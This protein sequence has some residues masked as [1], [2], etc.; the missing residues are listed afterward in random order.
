MDMVYVHV[1]AGLLSA[2]M[3]LIATIITLFLV[4]KSFS[5]KPGSSIRGV[6]LILFY[7]LFSAVFL[8]GGSVWL[9]DISRPFNM[10]AGIS[11]LIEVLLI[12][13][14]YGFLI[15]VLYLRLFLLEMKH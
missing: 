2:S 14:G 13:V 10:F 6:S 9:S 12:H 3:Q 15:L 8:Y 5:L 11:A 4:V 7:F 1:L